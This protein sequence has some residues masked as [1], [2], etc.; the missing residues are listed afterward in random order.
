MGFFDTVFG[1]KNEERQPDFWKF[2]SSEADL[3]A[4]VKESF[5]RTVVIFKHSTRCY[6][7]KTV[8][9]NFEK[10]AE[11]SG[12]DISFYLLDL[13]A[14]RDISDKIAE[15]FGVSHQ[16]PQILVLRDGKAVNNASHQSISLSIV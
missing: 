16:S 10:E 6:I 9:R 8:L 13:L 12:R 14:H 7:S 3:D 11:A 4:A 2:I 5:T 1:N 15:D